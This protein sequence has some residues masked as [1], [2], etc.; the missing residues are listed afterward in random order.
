M[1]S[2]VL[3]P[4]ATRILRRLFYVMAVVQFLNFNVM[5]EAFYDDRVA[6]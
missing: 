1:G 2:L 3:S 5:E 4:S 6:P